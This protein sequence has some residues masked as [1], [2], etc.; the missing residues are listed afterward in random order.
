MSFWMIAWMQ[1]FQILV[2]PSLCWVTVKRIMSLLKSKAQWYV[3]NLYKSPAYIGSDAI[4]FMQNDSY[5]LQ[6]GQPKSILDKIIT[7]FLDNIILDIKHSTIS[8]S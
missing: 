3:Y 1:K 7:Y 4:W 6:L 5:S 2:S 8:F